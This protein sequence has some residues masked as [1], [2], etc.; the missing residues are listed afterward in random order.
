MSNKL[1]VMQ[2]I[3]EDPRVFFKF[4]KVFDKERGELVPFQ[5]NNEQEELLEALL[6]H[7][8]IVVCKARQIGCSTLIRAY[9]L[10]KQYVET[11]PTRH[12]IISYTRDSADH[13]HSMDKGFYLCLPK[14]LQRK[15]SKSTQRTLKFN[16]T[17]AE[18]RAF[19][20][21][22][23]AGATRSFTFSSAHISEFAFFDD[24]EDLLANTIASCGN[25]QIIIET[26]PDGP[27][28]KYHRLC[29]DAPDNGWHLC[30]F[31]WFEHKAYKKKSQFH[32]KT[33]PDM[34]ED[35]E[36]I[37]KRH[38]LN[39]GQ[40]YWRRTQIQTMGLDKFK[41]EFPASVAEAFMSNSALFYPTDIVDA[42]EIVSLGNGKDM[43]YCDPQDGERYAMGVDVAHGTGKD[44]SAITV[45][46][47]TTLQPIYHY[48]CNT[49]LPATFA[50]KV[51][52][53]YWTFNEPYTIV[54]ANGPGSLVIHRL[55][56]FGTQKLYKSDKGKDWHT[57][58][59]N[60]LS[61]YDNLRELLCEGV[62]RIL[63]EKLWSEIRNT[64]TNPN[65]APHHP[66]GGNDDLLVSFV[67]ALEGAR[68]KPAPSIYG[69]RVAL[70]EEFIMKTKAR[71]I[72]QNGP[73]PFRRR[74]Q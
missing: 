32:Q 23:K 57:R 45:V 74:G 65:G 9:F 71:R 15:L 14:P 61:I 50:D 13:L 63:E 28:D 40:M 47:T 38:S 68:L 24:Q 26:T 58:K 72:R 30:F 3:T 25:G 6:T 34:T 21:G 17:G 8:R 22:G 20:G 43:W 36:E 18:L 4:L 31:P 54:E 39:K 16:D 19:T 7:N 46:S 35:E 62:I 1:A 55:E 69:V 49:I 12:A 27:G 44:Y 42:C 56:E 66:K 67:L 41:R 64:L 11:Q 5:M 33:V 70:M 52:D 48:R 60:K 10:W 59:E 53:I 51:W 37:M 2:K 73:L 29:M